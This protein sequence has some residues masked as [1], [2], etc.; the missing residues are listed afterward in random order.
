M[1]FYDVLEGQF[2]FP[3]GTTSGGCYS[4]GGT[5]GLAE[6]RNNSALESV[7]GLGPIPTGLYGLRRA[8][9]VGPGHTGVFVIPLT[10]DAPTRAKITSY[11]RGPD[12]FLNHGDNPQANFT[13]SDGCIVGPHSQRA[14]LDTWIAKGEDLLTVRSGIPPV[15]EQTEIETV[16]ESPE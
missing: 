12:S 1:I 4:G 2:T 16:E 9:L 11:G 6:Y 5:G 8:M 3:D 7:F 14:T 10:P 15:V 13:A